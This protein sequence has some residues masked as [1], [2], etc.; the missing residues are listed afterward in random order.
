MTDEREQYL[1]EL[2]EEL[3]RRIE[4]LEKKMQDIGR[5]DEA[6]TV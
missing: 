4:A 1:A 5:P 6:S 2:L 3:F